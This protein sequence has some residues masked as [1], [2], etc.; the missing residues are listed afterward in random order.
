[1]KLTEEI[2]AM[3]TIGVSPM[4]ALVVPRTL[5]AILLMPLLGFYSS[6]IAL[7]GGGLLVWVSWA[8]R[9]SPLSSASARSCRSPT[10]ISG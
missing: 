2:D 8:S 6:L 10:C 9:P 7:I 5:A 4:E 3:R 1:M